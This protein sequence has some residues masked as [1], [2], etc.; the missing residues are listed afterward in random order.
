MRVGAQGPHSPC[1]LRVTQA[2]PAGW[3]G[4]AN[5]QLPCLAHRGPGESPTD[6][7]WPEGPPG[8]RPAA[9]S[10]LQVL[11][12]YN[13]RTEVR[14][15]IPQLRV[16]DEVPAAHP[17]QSASWKPGQDWLLVKEAIKAGSVLDGL[18]PGLDCPHGAPIQR[19]SSKLSL[20][21]TQPW[22]PGPWPL[23][24]LVSGG[25]LP[26]SLLPKDPAPEGDTSNLTHGA[27][28]V[29]CG[30]PTKGLWERRHQ[31]QAWPVPEQLRPPRLKDPAAGAPSPGPDPAESSESPAL[32]S[33]PAYREL[34]LRSL[35]P[36]REGAVAPR[37]PRKDQSR[38][39]TPSG[40]L[41]PVP[42]PSRTLGYNLTPSPPKMP[43][44][45][46]SSSPSW[47]STGLQS[48]RRRL[49]ALCSL[50]P[51]LGQ[52]P[53]LGQGL[54]TVTAALRALEVTSGPSPPAQG[55]PAPKP[56]TDPAAR[57]PG[58]PCLPHLNP[59]TPAQFHP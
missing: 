58:L 42:E 19:L 45:S 26:E 33:L 15:R 9:P 11:R 35:E 48:G 53:G 31:C 59:I 21:E 22:A 32:A 2:S 34:R 51:G 7:S 14:K 47:G 27:S 57:P 43:M 37:G 28:R 54:A 36:Q 46:D 50:G 3:G 56:A 20:P 16:L 41:C 25:P 40:T 12:G 55:C 23:S 4:I 49:R 8:P 1:W 13:Y 30:N 10:P 24:V 39:K 38:P 44:P 5:P 29:L 17:G 18:L 6:Q 52:R